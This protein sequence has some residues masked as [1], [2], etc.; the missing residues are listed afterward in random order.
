MGATMFS[1]TLLA[2][3][4]VRSENSA[5]PA[6]GGSRSKMH[7]SDL[8]VVTPTLGRSPWLPE[9]VEDV[10]RLGSHLRV[11][12]VLVAPPAVVPGLR[13]RWPKVLVVAE[14]AGGGL[15]SALNTGV[16]AGGDWRWFTYLNDDDRLFPEVAEAV[17][18]GGGRDV[19]FGDVNYIDE[20]GRI[21]ARMPVCRCEA[22]I[23]DLLVRGLAAFT[24]QGALVGRPL[25]DR[26][27]G[28]DPSL[29]FVGDHEFWLRAAMGSASFVRLPGVVAAFR[30]HA[31][32][33]S[34]DADAVEAELRAV[35]GRGGACATSRGRRGA[36]LRFRMANAGRVFVR[37]LRSG[38]LRSRSLYTGR[39]VR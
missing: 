34:G 36:L 26:L 4:E 37:I 39:G 31:S 25:W 1:W 27:G 11:R 19:V 10:T 22:D 7:S 21:I 28:F 38:R 18:R 3:S 29:R 20:G 5:T 15:Y 33:L 32:Q 6:G 9:A 12:H 8:L 24:Q 30:I 17:R 16:A 35:L 13:E 14:T 2:P 23:P